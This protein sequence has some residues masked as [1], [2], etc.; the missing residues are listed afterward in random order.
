MTKE[1]NDIKIDIK[2]EFKIVFNIYDTIFHLFELISKIKG[3]TIYNS[4]RYMISRYKRYKNE[5]QKIFISDL[6]SINI[7]EEI[8]K[9]NNYCSIIDLSLE[10][11]YINTAI[12]GLITSKLYEK[13]KL[14]NKKRNLILFFDEAH[15]YME[16]T[17][18]EEFENRT[19][20]LL[21]EISREGR[22]YG[23]SLFISSQKPSDISEVIISQC[24][25]LIIHKIIS[26]IDIN[27]ISN[28]ISYLDKQSLEILSYLSPGTAIFSGRFQE[29]PQIVCIDMP[30]KKFKPNS[31]V[32]DIFIK[33]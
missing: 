32:E 14:E 11:V 12:A 4:I 30:T 8:L 7:I 22:K 17:T 28:V 2:E 26:P 29:F 25:N 15:K 19:Q 27:K 20:D 9:E 1:I 13:I 16:K 23:V 18:S 24:S 10:S 6:K 21:E 31:D 33:K 3:G 5:L